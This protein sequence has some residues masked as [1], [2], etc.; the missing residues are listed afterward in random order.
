MD[1]TQALQIVGQT[2]PGR[3]RAPHNED[4]IVTCPASGLV[5]LADGM[6]GYNAGEVA[7]NLASSVLAQRLNTLMSDMAKNL[8]REQAKALVKQRLGAEIKH[9]NTLIFDQANQ[10]LSCQG[11]GTTLVMGLFYDNF[12]AAAH[13]GDSRLYRLRRDRLEAL[14]RDHSL[15]QEQLDSGMITP[16]EARYSSNKNL[17][18]R[19]LGVDMAVNADIQIFEVEVGDLYLFCTDGLNDL[20]EDEDIRLTLFGLRSNPPLAAQ[21]LIRMANDSGGRDNVSV[22]LVRVMQDFSVTRGLWTQLTGWLR[23]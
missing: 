12:L 8:S 6:G 18:T 7:S 14:T 21:Q 13:V 17:V 10:D 15:L 9:A 11:M 1:L 22:V 3:V 20:V 5:V 2:D 4:S 23:A 19:A 16:D